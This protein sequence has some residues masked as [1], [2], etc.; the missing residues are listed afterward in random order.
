MAGRA[1]YAVAVKTVPVLRLDPDLGAGIAVSKRTGAE[2]ACLARTL[3]VPRGEWDGEVERDADRAGFGLLVLSGALCRRVSQ[4]GQHG[5]EL[6]G[7][8][9]LMR[10][11]D[12]IGEWASIPT[13]SGWLVIEGASLAVLG[14]EFAHRSAPYPPVAVALARRALLRSRYLAVM[15]AIVGQRKVETRLLMLFWHLADR[16]GQMR[17]EWV[18]IPL[19]LTHALLS[20]LVAARRPSVSTALSGLS[21]RGALVRDDSGWLLRGPSPAG[22]ATRPDRRRAR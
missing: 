9:D 15:M 6:I 8:G 18:Q 21:D 7:P 12:R 14:A 17:G 3:E 22:P 16:F 1:G 13:E 4:N 10:P 5:A 20:E 11:W 2:G 19:P